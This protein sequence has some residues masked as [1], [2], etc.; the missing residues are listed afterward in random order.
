[1]SENIGHLHRIARKVRER[2]HE[3]RL[4]QAI[5]RTGLYSSCKRYVTYFCMYGLGNRLQ[6]HIAAY[7]YS[8]SVG[9]QLVVRW[10]RNKHLN[11]AFDD[12]FQPTFPKFCD[13][14]NYTILR[15]CDHKKSANHYF[16]EPNSDLVVFDTQFHPFD[17]DVLLSREHSIARYITASLV[18]IP[19]I[20]ERV[21][22]GAAKFRRPIVGVHIRRGDWCDIGVDVPLDR[23]VT[24]LVSLRKRY[25][26]Q[27]TC[28]VSS[29]ADDEELMPFLERFDCIRY[30]NPVGP[31]GIL[32]EAKEALVDMLLLS[33][34]DYIVKTEGSSFSNVAAFLG[35]VVSICA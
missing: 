5:K 12:L 2:W 23:Y 22:A 13:Y 26:F 16:P 3:I 32:A 7:A 15:K 29:D 9:R 4:L 27:G 21:N 31:R 35:G 6:A 8:L 19:E 25:G 18:P 1:M 10:T 34:C 28:Y 14:K 33:R 20:A 17:L 30:S 24:A 11:A